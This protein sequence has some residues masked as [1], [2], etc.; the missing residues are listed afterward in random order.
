MNKK[1][2]KVI[3]ISNRL[4]VKIE[5]RNNT[6]EIIPSEGGLATGLGSIYNEGNN[7]WIGWPGIVPKDE[8]EKEYITSELRKRNLVPVFLSEEEVCRY[9]EGF[10]NEVLWPVFHYTP[11]YAVY[12]T[13]NWNTYKKVNERFAEISAAHMGEED[14]VWVHDY[15]LMLL[16]QLIRRKSDHISIGY[17][18][19][20]PFPPDELFRCIPWGNELLEGVL[21]ADLIAFHTFN[22]T[23]HFLDACT[24][25]LNIP[26]RDNSL[27]IKGRSVFVEVYPMGIDF[28]KFNSLSKQEAVVAR[29]EEI[30][31]YFQQK[32]II[33]SIDRLDYSK[34]ILP[35]ID[36][37]E[38]LLM[39]YPEMR[40]KVVLYMLVVPSRD[41]VEQ[42]K[43]LRDEIDRKVGNINAVYGTNDWTPIAYFYNSFPVEELTALYRASDICLITSIR[44]G[45]N[46]VCKE[47]IACKE[48]TQGVLI[49]SELAGAAKELIEAL[50]INPNCTDQIRDAI[51]QAYHMPRQEKKERMKASIA[52]VRKFNIHHWVNL[53]LT[54]L[55]EIKIQQKKEFARRIG[56]ET[57][58][59]LSKL[60]K[61]AHKR[62]FFLDYDGTLVGF[63]NDAD[64]ASPTQEIYGLLDSL[65]ADPTTQ[66]VIISGRPHPT[67]EKWFGGKDYI[68]VGEHGVWKKYPGEEWKSKSNLSVRW[69]P[70]IKRIMSKFTNRTAGSFIE[71]KEYSLAWHYRK[72]QS[73]LGQLRAQ[74][75]VDT[76]RY[77]IPH[78]GLQLLHGDKVIEVKNSEVNKGKAATSI[79]HKLQPDFIF[80]IGDDATDEDLFLELPS[81]KVITVKVGSK[82]SVAKFYV[83]SQEEV[84]KLLR[85]FLPMDKSSA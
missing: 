67:L 78:Q 54:R 10:S 26:I 84:I 58:G 66:I 43:L 9:Y 6:L 27:Q 71:E 40:E 51:F 1:K 13:D 75:L 77:L 82:K 4:P 55:R 60:Y 47:Y 18:Q 62:L 59:A 61:R 14:T 41:T 65:Q 2:S 68:L 79:V 20:I 8:N 83:E 52:L 16:P 42:Y 30:K 80:A 32:K 57:K 23:Q 44:D 35:R 46:L 53:F 63:H 7:L 64:K 36:A 17:F 48:N 76:M 31:E 39:H 85:T 73:G 5:R 15:Q 28:E 12:N 29:A 11:N 81:D 70:S 22:D 45:M 74:E 38:S 37:Y 24:H 69:K 72:A 25:I 50:Q 21:G 3:I 19:H 33:L 34:G 56:L 49:L